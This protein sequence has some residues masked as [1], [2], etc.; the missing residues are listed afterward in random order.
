MQ[1]FT[2]VGRITDEIPYQASMTP[3]FHPWRREVSFIKATETPI[4]DLIESL[5][6]IKDKKYWGYPF[7]RGLFEV[8]EADFIVI[9]NAMNIHIDRS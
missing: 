9:A 2:A 4:R 1:A 6:F 5:N 7:R 8:Q 3:D